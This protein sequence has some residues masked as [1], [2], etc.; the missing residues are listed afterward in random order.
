VLSVVGVDMESEQATRVTSSDRTQPKERLATWNGA[1]LF[2]CSIQT[3]IL[4]KLA[5]SWASTIE[6]RSSSSPSSDS[7]KGRL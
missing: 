7:R 1:A 3:K 2:A 6:V 4:V 5:P